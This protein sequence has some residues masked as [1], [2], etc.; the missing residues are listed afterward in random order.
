MLGIHAGD[1]LGRTGLGAFRIAAAQIALDNL[2]GV[3]GVVDSAKGTGDGADLTPH[4]DI[5]DDI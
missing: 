5:L 4:A 1:G 2:A 3:V